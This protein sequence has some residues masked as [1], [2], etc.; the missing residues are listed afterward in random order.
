MYEKKELSFNNLYE[1]YLP[2][3]KSVAQ[4]TA[5]IYSLPDSEFDDLLQEA[6]IALYT[7]AAAFDKERGVSF[8]VYARICIK[9]KLISY[10]N[11]RF[12]SARIPDEVSLDEILDIESD[13]TTPDK[14]VVGKESLDILKNTIDEMLTDFESS[15]LWLYISG[16]SYNDISKA[17]SK[18]LKT[19]DNA[20][21]RI[22]VKLRKIYPR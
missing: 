7:S 19:V 10:I 2:L 9:N 22:K 12:K 11:Q 8:G 13:D 15:V 1:S 14:F 21:H 4:K 16:M 3:M 6:A 17:L 18:P 5:E 20:L